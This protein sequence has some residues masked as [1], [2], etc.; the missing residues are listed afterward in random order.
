MCPE[1]SARKGNKITSN[2]LLIG[3]KNRNKKEAKS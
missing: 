2:Y 3:V 1:F